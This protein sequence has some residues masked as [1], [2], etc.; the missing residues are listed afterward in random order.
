MWRFAIKNWVYVSFNNVTS[1]ASQEVLDFQ[2]LQ[3]LSMNYVIDPTLLGAR[4]YSM[5]FPN[6][7]SSLGKSQ[8]TK[9]SLCLLLNQIEI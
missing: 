7:L 2:A 1:W 9:E 5:K 8:V 4:T 6:E 3:D